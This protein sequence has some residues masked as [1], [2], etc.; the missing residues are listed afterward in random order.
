[1][2]SVFL[3]LLSHFLQVVEV[4]RWCLHR[5]LNSLVDGFKLWKAVL[6]LIG[7]EGV[8]SL[9]I[10]RPKIVKKGWRDALRELVRLLVLIGFFPTSLNVWRVLAILPALQWRLWLGLPRSSVLQRFVNWEKAV[11]LR[12][13]GQK[14]STTPSLLAVTLSHFLWSR[15]EGLRSK[16][17]LREAHRVRLA[18]VC[19]E[20]KTQSILVDSLVH[21]RISLEVELIG[22]YLVQLRVLSILWLLVASLTRNACGTRTTPVFEFHQRRCAFLEQDFSFWGCLRWHA[23]LIVGNELLMRREYLVHDLRSLST[24]ILGLFQVE[25][26][27]LA[28]GWGFEGRLGLRVFFLEWIF[29]IFG[30]ARSVILGALLTNKGRRSNWKIFIDF[31]LGL[32]LHKLWRDNLVSFSHPFGALLSEAH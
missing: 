14:R 23:C 4:S 28:H 24:R 1:M 9:G 2:R 10:L 3:D 20:V 16:I 30:R 13:M 5:F 29:Q 6:N 31:V 17:P 21:L 26:Q 22:A 19:I 27:T 15:V 12:G 18:G 11:V 7:L 8:A 32:G 25:L